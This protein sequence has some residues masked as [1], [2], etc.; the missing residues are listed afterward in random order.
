MPGSGGTDE[1]KARQA[2]RPPAEAPIPT[3]QSPRSAGEVTDTNA[4]WSLGRGRAPGGSRFG[5]FELLLPQ[6]ALARAINYLSQPG[7]DVET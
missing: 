6:T 4:G 5:I 1:R 7:F 3:T 2:C